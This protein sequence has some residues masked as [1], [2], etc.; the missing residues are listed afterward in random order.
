MKNLLAWMGRHKNLGLL[1]A[2]LLVSWACDDPA[3]DA[4]DMNCAEILNAVKT[5]WEN[6]GKMLYALEDAYW[7]TSPTV[8][9]RAQ[10][11]ALQ[12][13]TKKAIKRYNSLRRDGLKKDC[14]IVEA[15]PE[16]EE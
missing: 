8:M 1:A 7:L 2:I 10:F 11:S 6:T 12:Q 9:E 5:E 16:R 3:S 13:E 4:T 14:P 15:Y